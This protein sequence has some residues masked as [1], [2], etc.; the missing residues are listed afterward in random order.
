M[1]KG[2]LLRCQQF[3]PLLDLG[4]RG[5]VDKKPRGAQPRQIL[6]VDADAA[7]GALAWAALDGAAG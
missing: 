4:V 3:E 5:G 1:M 6:F 7:I 2:T